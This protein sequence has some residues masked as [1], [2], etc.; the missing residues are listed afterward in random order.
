MTL[1]YIFEDLT[2]NVRTPP[3][4]IP[5]PYPTFSQADF[6]VENPTPANGAPLAPVPK[7]ANT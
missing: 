6:I 5:A 1:N 4:S 2:T 7:F 3:M